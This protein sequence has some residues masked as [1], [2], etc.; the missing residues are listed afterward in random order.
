RGT[1]VECEMLSDDLIYNSSIFLRMYAGYDA[2]KLSA[3]ANAKIVTTISSHN[4]SP[5]TKT[6]AACDADVAAKAPAHAQVIRRL[7]VRK[8]G[9]C[10]N[11][12]GPR[13]RAYCRVKGRPVA[14]EANTMIKRPVSTANRTA[15]TVQFQ[16]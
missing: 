14:S 8:S 3:A 4:S 10:Q 9:A 1:W 15:I 2:V 7:T 11:F 5:E 13:S 6:T 12:S 16:C